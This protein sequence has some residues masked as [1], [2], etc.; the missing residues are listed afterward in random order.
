MAQVEKGQQ[1]A[2]H[3]PSD[4]AL[5]RAR[6]VLTG[7]ITPADA[8]AE[9]D[10]KYARID[11]AIAV[12]DAALELAGHTR[13]E[14]STDVIRRNLTGDLTDEQAIDLLAEHAANAGEPSVS[15]G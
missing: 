2:G 10:A 13:S 8:R 5:D 4:E 1:L 3:F 11:R 12:A 7:E 14:F 6:R 15:G 9:I